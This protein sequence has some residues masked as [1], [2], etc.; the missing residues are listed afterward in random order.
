MSVVEDIACRELVEQLTDYLEGAIPD[1]D[2]VRIDAHLALCDGCTN[3]L[4]QLRITIR[5]TGTI[6]IDDVPVPQ[7]EA[8]RAAFNDW[9]RSTDR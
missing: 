9:R 5:V 3:A 4:D 2:R 8:M 6:G 7:R 1:A